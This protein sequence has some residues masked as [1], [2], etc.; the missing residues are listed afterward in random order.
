MENLTNAYPRVF[1]SYARSDGEEFARELRKR[2]E[3]E[4]IPL[5]Q[6]RV[7]M[8]G[9]RDWWLQITEAL[10]QVEFMVLVMTP[11]ALRSE[12]V[13]KEWR[14]ARQQG[15]GVYP[16]KADANLDFAG[17][18]RWMSS[19]HFY[20]LDHEW[21]KFVNDLNTRYQRQRIPFMV[22]DLPEGF[23][24]RPEEF[25]QL[26][27]LLLD[28]KRE[29]PVAITAALK[30][31]GGFGKTTLATALCHNED[32]Q[33][34]F[35]DGIL[36]V[37]LGENPGD[38]IGKIEDLIYMFRQERPG[39]KS[40]ETAAA[41]LAELLADREVLIVID[42]VWNAA[43]LKPFLQGGPR[44]ARLITT[45]MSDTLPVSARPVNVDAMKPSEA[46]Q[47][48]SSGI[49]VNQAFQPSFEALA[50]RLGEWPTLLK[51][52]NG[53]LRE[54]TKSLGQPLEEALAYINKALD[55]KGL[56]FFDARNPLERH[57]AIASTIGVS[58]ELLT[59]E[60]TLRFF[61]LA[62]FPEDTDIPLVTLSVLW[63]NTGAL[64]EFDV[65]SLC[66]KLSRFSL[67]LNFDPTTKT[68]RLHDVIRLYLIEQYKGGISHLHQTFLSYYH[69]IDGWPSLSNNEPYLW[70]N[71][72]FH[73]VEVGNYDELRSLFAND[74]WFQARVIRD[75]YIY[76]GYLSDLTMAWEMADQRAS[77]NESYLAD[78]FHYGLIQTSINSLAGNYIP[79]LVV[80]AVE[81]GLWS[82]E[83]ALSV[84]ER[85][86]L[87][88][89]KFR[90]FIL[91][92]KASQFSSTL[93]IG[94]Q[95]QA[96]AAALASEDKESRF[97]ALIEVAEQ[98]SGE[99]K[100]KVLRQ[101]LNA[102]LTIQNE[103][104]RAWTLT[105]V[106]EQLS[107]EE[108]AKV[109]RQ[110]LNA[111]KA[112]RQA[113]DTAL[114]IQD[115]TSR[116]EALITI[117]VK[118]LRCE[119]KAKVLQQALN[120]TLTI[121]NE[122]SRARML[123]AVDE[124]LRCEKKAK[125]LRQALDAALAIQNEWSRARALAEMAGQLKGGEKARVFRQAIDTALAIQDKGSRAWALTSTAKQL[126]GE[127]KAKVLQQALDAAL[128]IQDEK[129]RALTLTV[130]AGQL[131][132]EEKAKVLRQAL[133]TALTIQ[134]EK[135][136]AQ[137]LTAVAWQFNGEEKAKVLQQALDTALAIQ[138]EESRVQALTVVAGQLSRE[139][140]SPLHQ[141]ALDAALS[142]QNIDL[143]IKLLTAVAE[144]L[145]GEEK[146]PK[147]RQIIYATLSIQ[148]EEARAQVLSVVAE[149]LSGEENTPMLRQTLDSALT[150]PSEWSRAVALT[151]VAEQLNGEEKVKVLRQALETALTISNEWPRA[152]ALA[153]MAGQLS[154][155]EK[156]KVLR[157]A[158][159]TALVIQ[160]KLARC[161]ALTAVA[162][163]LSGEENT[164]VLRQ[165][166]YVTL[167]IQNEA[168]RAQVLSAVDEQLSGEENTPMLRQT[169]DA[170]LTIH[171]EASRAQVLTAVAEQLGGKEKAEVL[172]QALETTMV[173]ENEW[174]R[175]RAL[176]KMAG[177][178]SGEEKAMV[179]KKALETALV[180]QD[181]LALQCSAL[182]AVAE[183]L[184]GEENAL[185]LRQALAA[186]L[187]IEDKNSQVEALT[188][189][190]GKLSGE[191]KTKV[192]RQALDA[193]LAIQD[194]ES[195]AENLACL[196][197]Q[198]DETAVSPCAIKCLHWLENG[199]RKVFLNTSSKLLV[200]LTLPPQTYETIANSI[201]DVCNN[202]RWL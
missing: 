72:A 45:R 47:L 107:G 149:Q 84:S 154:G 22:A 89:Q 116:F 35:D 110:A 43:H 165:A 102:T 186:A 1:I 113:L 178:L 129:S 173:I 181:K 2:L 196:T 83:R 100:A 82:P 133:E 27:S 99:E 55:R 59:S 12:V 3:A 53:A 15:V 126:S 191:G 60:E 177:Q 92:L 98:L 32:I 64:D 39:F 182:T 144:Q 5:W 135:S 93:R 138:N 101:A 49:S 31:A 192:L 58:L 69:P 128:A 57:Q 88:V 127:E 151:A 70:G 124:Q 90:L 167:S 146:A 97:W 18:P 54:R 24:Q 21:P 50:K 94:A 68:I 51:L 193:A 28:Q 134:N 78:C 34:A 148:N 25:D 163:Q 6:D 166:I 65:E 198:L 141:Q 169:L 125:V 87:K 103:W 199:N 67:L 147:L 33:D 4:N 95:N 48:L 197:L 17:L 152:R 114:A 109:L 56:T 37:T 155:E 115:E 132:G 183:Q 118:Q 140:N 80:A 106:A 175:A 179:H 201:Y 122:W 195:R 120:A 171:D 131:S 63:G 150:I 190:A 123:T 74:Q 81:N 139:E 184:N 188:A 26:L 40:V 164:P 121:Q 9:G 180:I 185:M 44:C 71:L 168:S 77:E 176:T 29:N 96:L 119:E 160:D 159:D 42:D 14:Y 36:W 8:E 117:A 158:L 16:V 30:G 202:W 105:A 194:E 7:G 66:E 61:E 162:E 13:R 91:L 157:Q 111:S 20:D 200:N 174:S 41:R 85:I 104:S 136:R 187:A 52:V 46:V 153:E 145:S 112:L 189:V 73:L 11:N 156:A 161:S 143:Q 142:I 137:A 10:E 38:L 86:P 79:E 130:M 170:A 76:S 23:V 75:G 62:I 19:A 108:K 172:R